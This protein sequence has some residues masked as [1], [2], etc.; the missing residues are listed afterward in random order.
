MSKILA[1]VVL[2]ACGARA[3][4]V[5]SPSQP[6]PLAG[7]ELEPINETGAMQQTLRSG[8]QAI[9]IGLAHRG[10]DV[11]VVRIGSGAQLAEV[12]AV[13]TTIAGTPSTLRFDYAID[14]GPAVEGETRAPGQFEL[15]AVGNDGKMQYRTSWLF[16]WRGGTFAVSAPTTRQTPVEPCPACDA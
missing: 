9:A 7:Y 12:F 5:T 15:V 4:P 8:T 13:P 11:K 16:T 1:F 10:H 6:Q 2:A 3:T 14:P